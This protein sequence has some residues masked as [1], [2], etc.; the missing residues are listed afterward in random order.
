M[1]WYAQPI[2]FKDRDNVRVDKSWMYEEYAFPV[3]VIA[4]CRNTTENGSWCK[5]Q[6]EVDHW[7][8]KHVSYFVT[9]DTKVQ[10]DIW[11]DEDDLEILNQHPYYGDV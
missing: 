7:L 9:Q 11:G 10:T 6:E 3:T 2:C 5:S 8:T 1:D 4:Y